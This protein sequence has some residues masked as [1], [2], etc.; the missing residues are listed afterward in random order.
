MADVYDMKAAKRP[1]N[2]TVNSDLLE[3]AKNL[4]INISAVLE[5][6]LAESVKQKKQEEWLKENKAAIE[7]YNS[8]VGNNTIFSDGLRSF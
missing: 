8:M 1:A 2:L 4:K 6:A 3:Q 7:N 5:M